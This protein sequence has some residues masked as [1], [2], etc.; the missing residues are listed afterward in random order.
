MSG[1][2]GEGESLPVSLYHSEILHDLHSIEHFQ[3]M[4][5]EVVRFDWTDFGGI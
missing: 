3:R 4:M 2:F 5:K 1:C